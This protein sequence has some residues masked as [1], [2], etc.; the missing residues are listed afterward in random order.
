MASHRPPPDQQ[1]A[2]GHRKD[3]PDPLRGLPEAGRGDREGVQT[4]GRGDRYPAGGKCGKG[5][6]QVRIFAGRGGGSP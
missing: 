5:G 1:G 3:M 6:E 4:A 2:A